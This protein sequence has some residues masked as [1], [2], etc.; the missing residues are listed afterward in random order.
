[1][2]YGHSNKHRIQDKLADSIMTVSRDDGSGFTYTQA[3]R[4]AE[5]YRKE[6]IASVDPISGFVKFTHGAFLDHDVLDKALDQANRAFW[7]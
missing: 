3:S 1:M 2:I 6:K 5:Y 4:I 7:A